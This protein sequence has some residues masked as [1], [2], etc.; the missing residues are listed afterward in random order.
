MPEPLP[1]VDLPPPD[2]VG[3]TP[4]EQLLA[5]RRSVRSFADTT[6]DLAAVGQLLWAAQGVRDASGMRTSPSAGALYPLELY[7]VAG[8]VH[9][10]PAGTYHY[11]PDSHRLVHLA[12]G[13]RRAAVAAAALDQAWLA[14]APALI[15]VAA[16][17]ERTRSKYR[18]RARR[19]VR[20]EV[21]HAAQNLALQAAALGLGTVVV[22]AFRDADVREV[23]GLADPAQPVLILPVGEPA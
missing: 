14:E 18:T 21:G 16:V 13:D 7:L 9:G 1:A 6:L 15:V 3:A 20:I 22:G 19:Y 10:L 23:L 17:E 2:T 12:S 4:L 8:A 11:E 5:R